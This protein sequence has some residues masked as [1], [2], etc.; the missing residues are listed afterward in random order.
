ML[1]LRSY[2]F[3]FDKKGLGLFLVMLL[4][5]IVWVLFPTSFDIFK[6]PT[7]TPTLDLVLEA[8]RWILVVTQCFLINGARAI[9]FKVRSFFTVTGLLLLYLLG[10]SFY[11]AGFVNPVTILILCLAPCAAF[12]V[13]A[14]ASENIFALVASAVFAVAHFLQCVL[15]YL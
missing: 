13:F 15:N 4:P 14:A 6:K 2:R 8:F 7:A 10:W 11:Y 12:L 9:P 1:H 5:N 3:G